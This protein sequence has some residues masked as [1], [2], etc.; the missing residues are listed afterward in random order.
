M[1]KLMLLSLLFA[2]VGTFAQQTYEVTITNLTK[3]QIFSPP[4]VVS[5]SR[6]ISL[7]TEG[8][9]ASVALAALAEDGMTMPLAEDLLAND[10][11]YQ[12]V[13]AE[14]PVMPGATTTVTI[15]VSDS[16]NLIS[17]AGMLVITN[18]AF[19]AVRDARVNAATFKNRSGGAQVHMAHAY[20]A[21]SEAND[22]LCASIPGPPC[23]NAGVR[24][25]EGAEGYVYISNGI[26]GIGD[27]D[28]ET[29]DW[30][31][32]VARVTIQRAQ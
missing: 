8:E 18:D 3:G 11:V 28:S 16:R 1:R 14:G 15:E 26:H 21:G 23:G 30:R 12:V 13:A 9:P 10:E 4:A 6:F 25:T 32:P 2:S 7:F 27:I 20:D 29:Y 19:F 17:V 22:E 5:H 24:V 31:G